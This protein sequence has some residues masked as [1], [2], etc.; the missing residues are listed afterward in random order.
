MSRDKA[1]EVPTVFGKPRS[2]SCNTA[3]H[4]D[5]LWHPVK[6]ADQ[7]CGLRIDH[8]STTGRRGRVEP[9]LNTFVVSLVVIAP[10]GLH[11]NGTDPAAPCLLAGAVVLSC[12]NERN[13][14]QMDLPERL[15]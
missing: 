7:S 10:I 8:A 2:Y 11:A 15:A 13:Y 14:F 3:L 9:H 1:K 5:S 6:W 12:V 4:K